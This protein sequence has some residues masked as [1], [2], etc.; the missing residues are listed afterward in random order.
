MT[1]EVTN[2]NA[3]TNGS[4]PAEAADTLDLHTEQEEIEAERAAYN[5]MFA[6]RVAREKE[7][8]LAHMEGKAKAGNVS[9]ALT[10]LAL[11][12]PS[13]CSR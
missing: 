13:R 6:A 11:A 4:A 12:I 5:R 3:A 1:Y 8:Y 2:Q 7:R 9:A 10:F